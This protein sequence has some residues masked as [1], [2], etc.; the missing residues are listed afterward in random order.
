MECFLI[1]SALPLGYPCFLADLSF[2]MIPDILPVFLSLEYLCPCVDLFYILLPVQS[3][4]NVY[5]K[6]ATCLD[7]QPGTEAA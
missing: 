5:Y 6:K 4:A 1:F 3:M 2:L 7:R